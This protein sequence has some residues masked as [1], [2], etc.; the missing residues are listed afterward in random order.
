MKVKLNSG[1]EYW[2]SWYHQNPLSKNE[3]KLNITI[4]PISNPYTQCVIEN[5]TNPQIRGIGV[6]NLAKGD[7]FC[8]DKGRKISMKRAINAIG[9]NKETRKLFWIEYHKM[10]N[11]LTRI[12]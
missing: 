2:V 11:K 9:L 10:T 7:R 4:Y 1:V 6:A 3:N 5:K 12:K 8:K